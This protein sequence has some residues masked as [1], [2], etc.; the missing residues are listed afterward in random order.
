MLTLPLDNLKI[1][2][3][4]KNYFTIFDII[5]LYRIYITYSKAIVNFI[6]FIS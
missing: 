3:P 2:E 1:K 6:L 5:C 4:F